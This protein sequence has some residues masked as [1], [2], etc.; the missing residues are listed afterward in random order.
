M[1]LGGLCRLD[2]LTSLNI[3][4][5]VQ[6]LSGPAHFVV[7]CFSGGRSPAPQSFGPVLPTSRWTAS[8][9]LHGCGCGT[10]SLTYSPVSA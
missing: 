6:L 7:P 1:G 8:P 5:D 4:A 2:I 10:S 9:S 3:R